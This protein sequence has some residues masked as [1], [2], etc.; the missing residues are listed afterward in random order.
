MAMAA[1]R[2][3]FKVTILALFVVLTVGLSAVVSLMSYRRNSEATLHA[4]ERLLEQEG[5]RI[6]ATTEQLIEPLFSV[7]NSAVLLPGIDA[8]AGAHGEHL[9]APVMFSALERYPQMTALYI[10]NG[11]GDFYRIAALNAV[12]GNARAWLQAPQ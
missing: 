1:P 11:R 12:R 3:S 2:V 6:V 8:T 7:T 10:G 9:L 4:A 5:E